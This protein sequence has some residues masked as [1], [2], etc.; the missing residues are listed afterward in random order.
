MN[1]ITFETRW[2]SLCSLTM[3]Q[4]AKKML[5]LCQNCTRWIYIICSFYGV[6]IFI[7]D[8]KAGGWV[9]IQFWVGNHYGFHKV[10]MIFNLRL[11]T[12]SRRFAWHL[13]V[14]TGS[15]DVREKFGKLAR[16]T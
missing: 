1:E 11:R 8:T 7:T 5:L 12:V 16:G 9:G 15:E 4:A 3:A 13:E 2:N 14:L 10:S 6:S